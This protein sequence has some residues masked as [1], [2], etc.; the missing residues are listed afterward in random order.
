M[1]IAFEG[2]RILRHKAL[3]NDLSEKKNFSS[4]LIVSMTMPLKEKHRATA[5]RPKPSRR[6][7]KEIASR[8]NSCRNH[9]NEKKF[10]TCVTLYR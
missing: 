1:K 9:E 4:V 8:V 2:K 3:T 5:N 6:E 10:A 7:I